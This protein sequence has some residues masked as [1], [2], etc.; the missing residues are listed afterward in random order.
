[1]QDWIFLSLKSVKMKYFNIN[2][3]HCREEEAV[4]Q[5]VCIIEAGFQI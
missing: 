5:S 1:M 2:I 4:L 3:N